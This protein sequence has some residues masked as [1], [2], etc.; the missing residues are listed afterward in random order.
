MIEAW[1]REVAFINHLLNDCDR[2]SLL[3]TDSSESMCRLF[4]L[5]EPMKLNVLWEGNYGRGSLWKISLG[6]PSKCSAVQMMTLADQSIL[7]AVFK[8]NISWKT[9]LFRL[10][11]N[12]IVWFTVEM[13]FNILPHQSVHIFCIKLQG[14]GEK[15]QQDNN[16][17]VYILNV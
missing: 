8:G 4:A 10:F 14:K 1:G 11:W 2:V 6:S 5:S 16:L 15:S 13:Y 3:W 17:W 7:D 9:L 12:G